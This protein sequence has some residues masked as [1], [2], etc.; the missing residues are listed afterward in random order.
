MPIMRI[1]TAFY[2]LLALAAFAQSCKKSESNKISTLS[3]KSN[4]IIAR[5]TGLSSLNTAGQY[6]T[7]QVIN[8]NAGY[9]AEV[10]NFSIDNGGTGDLATSYSGISHQKWRITYAGNGYF[11]IMNLGS[12]KLAQSYNYNGTQVLLQN[13]ADSLDDQLWSISSVAG[14]A[15]R[16][17]NKADGLAV[18]GNGTGMIQLATYTGTSSQ[19]WGYNELPTDSYRD[20]QV[21]GFFHRASTSLHSVAFDQGNSI[22]LSDGHELWITED[23]FNG[24]ELAANGDIKCNYVINYRNSMLIQPISHSWNPNLTTNITINN[25]TSNQP[26]QVCN[27]QPGTQ[28]TWPGQ[29]IELNGK[30]YVG[31]G[32][33]NGLS[34]TGS[35]YYVFTENPSSLVW[36]VERDTVPQVNNN[37]A[38]IGYGGG[39]YKA[40][41]GYIYSFGSKGVFFNANDLFVARFQPSNF[42]SW[43]FWNG[44]AWVNTPSAANAAVIGTSQQNVFITFWHGKYIMM[45]MD[46]GFFCD[47]GSHN[48]YLSTSTSPTGPFSAPIK[49]WT[50]EDM[51]GGHI[52]KYY[53]PA[54]HPEFDNGKSELLLTYSVNFSPCTVPSECVNG[55]EPAK[56][57]QV[58]GVRVPAS[59]I[60]LN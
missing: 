34:A 25:S 19:L 46:E 15:Y 58:K 30:V 18:T 54:M 43:T 56:Y 31:A 6:G 8:A 21:V 53:T 27:I 14:K 40:A 39:Y 41:D 10:A 9:S 13:S 4:D 22:P 17:I 5:S 42:F 59:V 7:F 32:E 35:A 37:A 33:G 45:Q 48:I 1:K 29:G 26:L 47:P 50:I 36:A 55:T 57:Y 16:V 12:G 51:D 23:A 44:S 60:G 38:G 24:F 20:D 11:T 52:I 3:D 28:W 2:L 49:V